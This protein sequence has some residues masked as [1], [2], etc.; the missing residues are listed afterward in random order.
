MCH[1]R[2]PAYKRSPPRILVAW[3]CEQ[4]TLA[5]ARGR[6]SGGHALR[7]NLYAKRQRPYKGLLV[8]G[9]YG[10]Y[11]VNPAAAPQIP[12]D[13]V[14]LIRL[15]WCEGT[16]AVCLGANLR[17]AFF[18]ENQSINITA[19]AEDRRTAIQTLGRPTQHRG[20][21]SSDGQQRHNSDC[22]GPHKHSKLDS[23]EEWFI[24]SLLRKD[25]EALKAAIRAVLPSMLD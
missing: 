8:T 19:L 16:S 4:F 17:S 21:L 9:R 18:K 3:P 14:D 20:F 11:F 10:C 5:S 13:N 22:Y 23:F 1:C 25:G 15:F 24:R 12:A 6:V 7:V 2:S